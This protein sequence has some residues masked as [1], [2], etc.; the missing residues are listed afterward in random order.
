M[1]SKEVIL[2]LTDLHFTSE[3]SRY[4]DDRDLA[5][6]SL[7]DV[8]AALPVDWRPS[9]LCLIALLHH[10]SDWL[11]PAERSANYGQRPNTFDY[12]ASRSDLLLSGHTHGNVR[13]PDI[14]QQTSLHFTGGATYAG[15][16][17]YNN[18]RLIRVG[19]NSIEY[20][21]YEFDPRESEGPWSARRSDAVPMPRRAT[22]TG[23]RDIHKRAGLSALRDKS[24]AFAARI[25]RKKSRAS[26]STTAID[27]S[28]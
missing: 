16:D 21:A 18:F 24:E 28:D 23:G 2:H 9:V 8:V 19:S 26:A 7:L 1:V 17:Y 4:R 10:P 20:Q 12:V 11:H 25:I 6:K 13:R 5:L 15:G 14:I 3:E 22:E 27:A